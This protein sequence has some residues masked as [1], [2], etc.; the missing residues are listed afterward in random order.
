MV[1]WGIEVKPG[2]PFTH[3]SDKD[4]GRLH[5][6]QATLGIGPY[7]NKSLVQC[8]VGNK[9]PVLMCV[10]LPEK[11]ESC[12]LDLEFEEVDDVVFSV[13]GP[14]SAHLTGYYVGRRHTAHDDD[15]DTLGEDIGNA[16]TDRSSNCSDDSYEDSFINDDEVETISPS[17]DSYSEETKSEPPNNGRPSLRRLKK[18]HQSKENESDGSK[19]PPK[20]SKHRRA[21]RIVDS[22]DEDQ[23]TIST[24]RKSKKALDHGASVEDKVVE[25]SKTV[26]TDNK[27]A[28]KSKSTNNGTTSRHDEESEDNQEVK[29]GKKK[30]KERPT[31]EKVHRNKADEAINSR[32]QDLSSR[33]EPQELADPK[34][35]DT[36][37]EDTADEHLSCEKIIKKKR[38]SNN[39]NIEAETPTSIKQERN[40]PLLENGGTNSDS[41]ASKLI[42]MP[43][44]LVIEDLVV[45]E[46][47]HE[48]ASSGKKVTIQYSIKLKDGGRIVR[49]S[50]ESAPH[51]FRLGKGRAMEGL[52]MG[53]N[54]M[55][56][57][58]RRRLV[59][60][61]ALGFGSEDNDL[62]VPPNSWLVI[63]VDLIRVR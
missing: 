5:I 51:K 58:G 49:S 46:A 28:D 1:F 26:G 38:R 36:G 8:N 19:S 50:V 18:K 2:K 45:G 34:Q 27:N 42:K 48:V 12:H 4:R 17:L 60:P 43:N 56:V 44:G 35:K 52:D 39:G 31:E 13:I 33:G 30:R 54:G 23:R 40:T 3:S 20:I 29:P 10:L 9:S 6:S 59:I 63:D 55:R 41:N 16:D 61:P 14:R 15:S 7:T 11:S 62:G 32:K 57:G 21:R 47:D 24:L 37:I 53:I 22:D 25:A